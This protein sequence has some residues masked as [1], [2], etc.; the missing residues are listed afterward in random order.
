MTVNKVKK[1]CIVGG[2]SAGWLTAAY[3]LRN[4]PWVDVT[5][6]ESANVP[7]VGV[8]EA[9]IINFGSFMHECDIAPFVWQPA[10][11]AVF[12][13]G[14][15]FPNWKDG[16]KTVW[17]PFFFE[18]I[19]QADGKK[20]SRS[21]I[22]SQANLGY[23]DWMKYATSWYNIAVVNNEIPNLKDHRLGF[24]LDAI[25]LA[26]FLSEYLKK[27]YPNT[28]RHVVADVTD[29]NVDGED[30]KS[31]KANGQNIS[32]DVFIDCTG[33]KRLLTSKIPGAEIVRGDDMLFA[34]AAVAGPV[35]YQSPDEVIVPYTICQACDYGWIWKTAIDGRIGSGL[36]YDDSLLSKEDAEQFL[37]NH[38]GKERML[39][40]KFN[41]I[42]F[43]PHYDAV[44][45]RGNCFSVGLSSGFI[46]PL[47]SSGL[48]LLVSSAKMGLDMLRKHYYTPSDRVFF[49]SWTDTLF[50]DSMDFVALH[51]MNNDRPGPF[52]DKVRAEFK[53][54][55]TLQ[56]RLDLNKEF[57]ITVDNDQFNQTF[58][59]D[60]WRIWLKATDN[61]VQYPSNTDAHKQLQQAIYQESQYK[62]PTN[63][64][65]IN[66]RNEA[67]RQYA[68]K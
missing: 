26:K 1:I 65:M 57:F 46:E 45:W 60:S 34:N 39:S 12:K 37:I 61:E 31:I 27:R 4:L 16:D 35:A 13:A 10:C 55:E 49:N 21:V 23:E 54:S 53:P 2:G 9:T 11:D 44:N 63:K 22:G 14:I 19:P 20:L 64:D 47:E 42:K 6:V 33:F 41:H 40:E 32:A 7:T 38:W 29:V 66:S 5:V 28:L 30:I 50:R 58:K 48:A 56:V 18:M 67:V 17:H 3:A 51:Y 52:W 68:R 8:G 15:L 25:K 62:G 43:T 36:V 24:H 59:E